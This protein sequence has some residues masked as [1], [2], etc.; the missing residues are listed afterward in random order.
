VKFFSPPAKATDF[1]RKLEDA[2]FRREIR[3]LK[4]QSWMFSDSKALETCLEQSRKKSLRKVRALFSAGLTMTGIVAILSLFNPSLEQQLSRPDFGEVPS[5]V[6]VEVQAEFKGHTVNETLRLRL[7]PKLLTSAQERERIRICAA[8]LHEQ[9]LGDNASLLSVRSD[10]ILPRIH[11]ETGVL[12]SWE[13]SDPARID[14]RGCVDLIGLTPG[15]TVTLSAVLSLGEATARRTYTIA[16]APVQTK[17]YEQSLR[18]YLNRLRERLSQS[19]PGDKLILPNEGE[20]DI[21]LTWALPPQSAW[22]FPLLLCLLIAAGIYLSQMDAI[23]K[24]LR[25]KRRA[26]EEE[27]PNLSLQLTLLL[28]A[29]LVVTAAFDEILRSNKDRSRPL[30]EILRDIYSRCDQTNESFV[31]ALHRFAQTTGS[32]D[33]LRLSTLISDHAARGSELAEKLERERA[34]LWEGRLQKARASAKEVET[35]LCLPMMLLLCVL[36]VIAIAPALME[37]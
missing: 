27:L 10:L 31:K 6:A 24:E 7:A 23:K 5:V 4:T 25:K 22:L 29:G 2:I 15:E 1:L 16:F 35:K 32:R 13:S 19:A 20:Y 18:R 9:M 34:S 37:M 26:V 8:Q 12:L 11:E 3:Q 28:N 14:L 33:F 30:Y 36:V 21:S 17:D